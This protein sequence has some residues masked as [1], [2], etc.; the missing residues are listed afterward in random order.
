MKYWMYIYKDKNSDLKTGI[1]ST[2][3]IL[4]SGMLQSVQVV[5]LH[6]SEIPFDA[7]A[8]KHLLDTLSKKSV[9]DW[10]EK[11]REVTKIWLKALNLK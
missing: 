7:I 6:P 1:S 9:T 2:E 3:Y 8:H 11:H 10:I 5:Y 4:K